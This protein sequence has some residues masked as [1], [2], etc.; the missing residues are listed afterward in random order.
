MIEI[1]GLNFSYGD[2]FTLDV[3]SLS[4]PT[5]EIGMII[6]PN[7]SGKSTLLRLICG[8]IKDFEG[9]IHINGHNISELDERET[10]KLISYVGP[11]NRGVAGHTVQDIV[12]TGRYPYTGGFG[13]LTE[14]D[15]R[16]VEHALDVV[17]LLKRRGDCITSL[18]SGQQQRA[19]IARAV[20][21]DTPVIALDEPT[22]NLDPRYRKRIMEILL[23]LK[24]RRTVVIVEHDLNMAV[25][26]GNTLTGFVDG[27]K[28]LE[29]KEPYSGLKERLSELYDTDLNIFYVDGRFF[30]DF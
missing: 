29:M 16:M 5:G 27:K 19:F 4:L 7:G 2:S 25:R 28:L 1:N 24:V 3:E 10:A 14:E 20:A 23:E 9:K 21:Q 17:G 6:G 26:M 13:I 18:S 30:I 11:A 22:A 8:I 15:N 12:A